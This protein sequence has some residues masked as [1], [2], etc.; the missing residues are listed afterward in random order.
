MRAIVITIDDENGRAQME[1]VNLSVTQA[2]LSLL[3]VA[4]QVLKG[5]AAV[6]G[7]GKVDG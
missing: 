2:L 7:A 1:L 3:E 5:N 6:V 4:Q